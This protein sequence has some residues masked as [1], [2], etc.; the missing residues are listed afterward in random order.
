MTIHIYSEN[1]KDPMIANIINITI[2][3]NIMHKE[4]YKIKLLKSYQIS[5]LDLTKILYIYKNNKLFFNSI[6]SKI[7]EEGGFLTI[8]IEKPLDKSFLNERLGNYKEPIILKNIFNKNLVHECEKE[9]III[10]INSL[11]F[12]YKKKVFYKQDFS[13]ILKRFFSLLV[14]EKPLNKDETSSIIDKITQEIKKRNYF[15]K[16]SYSFDLQEE[17]VNFSAIMETEVI[18]NIE[19]ICIF[20]NY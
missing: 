12:K 14:I 7:K 15:C 16:I 9:D 20:Q 19:E 4:I 17:P 3:K 6:I 13:E 2:E 10:N 11:I 5:Q 1:Q 8:F 18:K